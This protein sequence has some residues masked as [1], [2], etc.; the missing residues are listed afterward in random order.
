[1]TADTIGEGGS[2]PALTTAQVVVSLARSE[3]NC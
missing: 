1:M 3:T 2:L